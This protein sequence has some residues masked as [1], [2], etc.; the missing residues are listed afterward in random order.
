M[1]NLNSL[2]IGDKVKFGKHQI[3]TEAKQDIIWKVAAK[4][5]TGY[6]ANSVT[7]VAEKIMD[8]RGFDAKEPN[9][10][11]TDRRSYG[12]N[13]YKDSNLRQWLN[14]ASNPWFVKTHTADE[15]PTDGGMNVPTGYDNRAGF[16]SAFTNDE[17]GA[18]LNTSLKVAKNTVTDGGGYE[19]V[20]DKVFLLSNTEVGLANEN[21]IAEGSKLPLF[22]DNNSRIGKATQQL[23][24]NTRSS[25]KPA[26]VN[27]AWYWWL[28]TPYAG[29]SRYVRYV[30]T[31]GSLSN[32][33]AFYG[34][35][36][37]RP[38][39][40]LKSDIIVSDSP[41]SNGVYTLTYN[42]P[43]TISGTDSNLGD[44]ANNFNIK[45]Q[46]NDAD[47]TDV[48]TLVESINGVVKRTVSPA[49]RAFEYTFELDVKSLELGS[50][51]ATIKVSD[52]KG[53]STTRTYTF[54]KT[55][56]PP[57]ISGNDENLGDKNLGF[58]VVYQVND[59]D[60]DELT[61]T[62]KLNGDII[63]NMSNAPKL[64]DLTIDISDTKLRE[65][66]L[67]SSNTISIEAKDP[68]G[69]V[70]FRAYTF[71][72]V[73]TPPV[74]SG[75]D[76]DLG[77][78]SEP[79]VKEYIVT[80]AESNDVVVKEFLNNTELKTYQVTLGEANTTV[81]SKEEFIKLPNGSHEFRIEATDIAG[82]TTYRTFIF[83]KNEVK[84]KFKLKTPFL[85]DAMATKIFITP[86]WNREG[87]ESVKVEA[88]NNAFDANPTWE[89]I[90]D[91]VIQGRH[92]NLT[93]DVKT[94][95]NWGVDVRIEMIRAVDGPE[96][97]ITGFG[98][99]FE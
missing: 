46:I 57:T 66:A 37:V 22:T 21:S 94:D 78:V 50:H 65:L 76:E 1:A 33:L 4:N 40:N 96:I 59:A 62:E 31:A 41:D 44:K 86:T 60:G 68:K 39:L 5:H 61:V 75:V 77:T 85:T 69:G 99:A 30:Y 90:T 87:A 71:K 92:F 28:R 64:S 95:T 80:D 12:N 13:R 93:N 27:D 70:A 73:N 43:P 14:K 6:P 49:Q 58:Q 10:S 89:D 3:N 2:N 35:Y 45:Y 79:F 19:T 91:L 9:N 18:I 72:R 56:T 38:A 48:L 52:D 42:N 88:C 24:S 63:R 34:H 74:I 32:N 83:T 47:A 84:I 97:E 20:E 25:S 26:T 82:S 16:L 7:L 15:P 81:F 36:G 53:A 8:L 11:N 29:Y 17:L 55:N 67:D 23:I 98:G 51:T 54:R